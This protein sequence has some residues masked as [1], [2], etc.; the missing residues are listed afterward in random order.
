MDFVNGDWRIQ[1]I[2]APALFHP[3]AVSPGVVEVPDDGCAFGRQ[4]GVE[5]ERVGLL[6]A[7]PLETGLDEILVAQPGLGCGNEAFP[8]PAVGERAQRMAPA[9]PL[10][11]VAD[12]ADP[13][14][15]GGPGAKL[16]P[17][18]TIHRHR[19]RAPLL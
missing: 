18:Y 9:V 10:V 16:N 1:R 5:R 15:G 14:G 12:D 8:Y 17:G 2:A 7:V 6:G 13:L 11:E 19:T 3:H 4:F